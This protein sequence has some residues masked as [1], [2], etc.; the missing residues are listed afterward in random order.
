MIGPIATSFAVNLNGP[1]APM[2]KSPGLIDAAY[3][4]AALR[5][6]DAAR[7]RLCCR[8][9]VFRGPAAARGALGLV[10]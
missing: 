1:S 7:A 3:R 6:L 10:A 4:R 5:Q 8:H 2:R 9:G